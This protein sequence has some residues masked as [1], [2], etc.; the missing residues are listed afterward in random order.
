MRLLKNIRPNI[1][2][3][4]ERVIRV[5]VNIRIILGI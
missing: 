2:V 4:N 1:T 5:I 3:D